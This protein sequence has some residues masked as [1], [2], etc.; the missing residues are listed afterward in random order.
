MKT[1]YWIESWEDGRIGF[2]KDDIHPVLKKYE[3]QL[4][5]SKSDK[6][7]IPLCG[8]SLDLIWFS[9][10]VSYVWGVELSHL[11][12]ESFSKENDHSFKKIEKAPFSI[13]QSPHIT[14]A[15]GDFFNFDQ[16]L[17]QITF[18]LIYDRAAL[19]AL[20][21][22]MRENY[23]DQCK[24]N[25]SSSGKILLISFE[26]DQKRVAGPPFS[27]NENE[28]RENYEQRLEL[29]VELLEEK[30]EEINNQKF[31]D[32]GIHDF[33]QKTYLISR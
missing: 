25:L 22:V 12:I 19:V 4:H 33:I 8:K 31:I 6:V 23:Y 27:V 10:K 24:R 7:L 28:I 15:C 16:N 20:P 26:Y 1:K 14:I 2:H 29:K 17:T 9:K 13:Y 32:Q 21:P 3:S 5:L 18:D 11:A 30:R